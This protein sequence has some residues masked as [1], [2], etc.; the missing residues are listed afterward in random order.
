M[1]ESV[2]KEK[3][4]ELYVKN[5]YLSLVLAVTGDSQHGR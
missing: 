2:E 5:Q 3:K 4:K 1:L